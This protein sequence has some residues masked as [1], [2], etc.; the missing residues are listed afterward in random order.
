MG[1][2]LDQCKKIEQDNIPLDRGTVLSFGLFHSPLA[3]STTISPTKER[4]LTNLS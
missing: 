2:S 1:Y 4:F 3:L